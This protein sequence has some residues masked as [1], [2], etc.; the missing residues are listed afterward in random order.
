M[1]EGSDS[2]TEGYFARV[3][4]SGLEAE[5]AVGQERFEISA[6]ALHRWGIHLGD[7][8]ELVGRPGGHSQITKVLRFPASRVQRSDRE[9]RGFCPICGEA[10][11]YLPARRR[12]HPDEALDRTGKLIRRGDKVKVPWREEIRVVEEASPT[13]VTV[14][15]QAAWPCELE[16]VGPTRR[17]HKQAEELLYER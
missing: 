15:A 12:A 9:D 7:R 6:L 2:Q 1:S 8:I 11:H 17:R 13:L 10:E 3:S 5:L 14:D 4:D 16:R